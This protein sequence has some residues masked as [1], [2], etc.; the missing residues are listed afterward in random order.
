MK[1]L[2][3]NNDNAT[4]TVKEVYGVVDEKYATV[5]AARLIAKDSI[6]NEIEIVK[7]RIADSIPDEELI[8]VHLEGLKAI[9]RST[10]LT[11]PDQIDPD[12]ATRHKYLES[13]Y[14]IKKL[15]GDED[16]PQLKSGNTYNIFFSKEIQEN[17][18]LL[19]DKI[20][21]RL[22]QNVSPN[23]TNQTNP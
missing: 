19:E 6:S 11:E 17:V 13:G 10:S 4:K 12:Y 1:K 22:K 14:K 23:Q 9:K 2:I 16:K 15:Y 3:K 18:K 8:R 7:N 5:K 21:E 20:K